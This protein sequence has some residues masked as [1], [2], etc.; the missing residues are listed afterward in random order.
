[1]TRHEITLPR[2]TVPCPALPFPTLHMFFSTQRTRNNFMLFVQAMCVLLASAVQKT[3][4]FVVERPVRQCFP[5]FLRDADDSNGDEI[6]KHSRFKGI[7]E[8][9]PVEREHSFTTWRGTSSSILVVGCH[10]SPF[11]QTLFN[12]S[13]CQGRRTK[14]SLVRHHSDPLELNPERI[15]DPIAD[16]GICRA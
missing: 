12:A 8:I 9:V 13:Q 11:L 4:S 1:M 16:R 7:V 15:E 6:F 14:S 5:T 3:S 2:C 10:R